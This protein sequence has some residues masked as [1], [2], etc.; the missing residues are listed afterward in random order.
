MGIIKKIRD[1]YF[2]YVITDTYLEKVAPGEYQTKH[3][4]KYRIKGHKK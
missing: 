4:K 2:D 1:K 3:I